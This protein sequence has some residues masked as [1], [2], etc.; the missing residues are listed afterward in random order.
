MVRPPTR[1]GLIA[2]L[3]LAALLAAPDPSRA[4]NLSATGSPPDALTTVGQDLPLQYPNIHLSKTPD[5][6]LHARLFLAPFYTQG[7]AVWRVRDTTLQP[8]GDGSFA[9]ASVPFGLHLAARAGAPSLVSLTNEDRV[10]MR[11]AVAHYLSSQATPGVPPSAAT[12]PLL[13][14]AGR[15]V[16]DTI[17][18][19]GTLAG[20]ADL[21]IAATGEGAAVQFTVP[22]PQA[23]GVSLALSL[24][25]QASFGHLAGGAVLVSRSIPA[26]GSSGCASPIQQP[27]Y[28][29]EAP[30]VTGQ[31]GMPIIGASVRLQ[32]I[33][34][35]SGNAQVVVRLDRAWLAGPGRTF[36]LRVRVPVDTAASVIG[37]SLAGSVSS[38][39]P[40]APAPPGDLVVGTNGSCATNGILR[41]DMSMPILQQRILTA[42]LHLYAPGQT[43]SVGVR[44][45]AGA[46]PAKETF[47]AP[48]SSGSALTPAAARSASRERAQAEL[49]KLHSSQSQVM[50]PIDFSVPPAPAYEPPS[51][52]TAP[53]APGARGLAV[54]QSS[55][56][57]QVWDV[58]A[59]VQPW[60]SQ[61]YVANGGL[62][63]AASGAPMRFATQRGAA[64][65]VP[66]LAPYLDLT[67]AGT[68][69]P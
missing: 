59:I 53:I 66:A 63:L 22:D 44:V 1:L 17:T 54:A 39:A 49:P 35:R 16:G 27:E 4:R 21:A 62:V 2:T 57:W 12:T 6:L 18:Y 15:A 51:W 3:V 36:P 40:A 47:P 24:D 61:G 11:I 23:A 56:P 41:F 20:R 46:P 10:G 58:T 38:C 65:A 5:G 30:L 52:N 37:P 13:D 14:I 33:R 31:D 55:G 67:F 8:Q 50:R 7:P 45:Y 34:T 69:K 19:H 32:I 42:T 28:V 26:C 48:A 29:L 64:S 68:A 43:R 9:P 25:H 60:I